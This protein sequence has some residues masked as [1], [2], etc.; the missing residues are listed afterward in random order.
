MPSISHCMPQESPQTSR[1]SF[2]HLGQVEAIVSCSGRNV[3]FH[4]ESNEWVHLSS[5]VSSVPVLVVVV[6]QCV[7]FISMNMST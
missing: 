5:F 6:V 1:T 7:L 2:S 3:I 4:R